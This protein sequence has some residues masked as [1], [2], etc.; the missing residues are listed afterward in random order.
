MTLEIQRFYWWSG[1]W[2]LWW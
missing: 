1:V 2:H